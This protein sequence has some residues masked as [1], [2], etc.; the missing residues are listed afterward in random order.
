MDCSECKQLILDEIL[1]QLDEA[2][3]RVLH[4]HLA[5]CPACRT[6]YADAKWLHDNVSAHKAA[7]ESGHISVRLLQEYAEDP[8]RLDKETR[9]LVE[10]HLDMCNECFE[11][12][13]AIEEMMT[14]LSSAPVL[15]APVLAAARTEKP[16]RSYWPT[17]FTR[18]L[19]L[20]YTSALVAIVVA[21]IM[22]PRIAAPPPYSD[23][24]E[25]PP[26]Y[27]AD[28]S[29]SE[30]RDIKY[31]VA[32]DPSRQPVRPV[33]GDFVARSGIERRN[34][35]TLRITRGE[36]LESPAIP[37]FTLSA[38]D[39]LILRLAVTIFEEEDN[40]YVAAITTE[41]GEI[42]WRGE[43]EGDLLESGY[44]LLSVAT[45]N[46]KPDTYHIEV[47]AI[48]LDGERMTVARSAF[49]FTNGR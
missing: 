39:Y 21:L 41:G 14:E 45:S 1:G 13:Q 47:M 5:A 34:L 30:Q 23:R 22:Y 11:D 19:V 24:L 36:A 10:N 8:A 44:L 40:V 48:S 32:A 20:A 17:L 9:A 27:V 28:E 26:G 37:E 31:P 35:P 29:V 33:S 43:V 18:R 49:R 38:T 3:S 46:F 16:W 15:A 25:G 4:E 2:A 7:I 6:E 42:V 12:M